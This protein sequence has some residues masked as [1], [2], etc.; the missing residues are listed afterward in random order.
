[1]EDRLLLEGLHVLRVQLVRGGPV[2][3]SRALRPR[4][5]IQ[6]LH[7]G[8]LGARPLHF[9]AGVALVRRAHRV[10]EVG[11]FAVA[12]GVGLHALSHLLLLVVLAVP[13]VVLVVALCGL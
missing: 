12:V 4:V 5:F 7:F 9:G 13:D 8:A 1:M 2:E 10:Q 6:S 11:V 3:L